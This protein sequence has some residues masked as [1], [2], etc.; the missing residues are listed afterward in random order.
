[1]EYV[2]NEVKLAESD[3]EVDLSELTTNVYIDNSKRITVVMV[4]FIR[5]KL[6]DESIK[7]PGQRY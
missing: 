4:D 6:Y 7:P 1:M 5:G 2:K 3:P